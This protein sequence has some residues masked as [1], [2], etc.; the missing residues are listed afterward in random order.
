MKLAPSN[1]KN[2]IEVSTT[3]VHQVSPSVQRKGC[4]SPKVTASVRHAPVRGQLACPPPSVAA[5]FLS[6]SHET[7]NIVF[8]ATHTSAKGPQKT[9]WHFALQ[10]LQSY[11]GPSPKHLISF[12]RGLPEASFSKIFPKV[13]LHDHHCN[14]RGG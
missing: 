7:R 9:L 8:F 14:L 1:L 3:S 5:G 10:P 11:P 4:I 12:S 6:S 13:L 2:T